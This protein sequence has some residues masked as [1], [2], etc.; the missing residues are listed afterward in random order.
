[1]FAGHLLCAAQEG[2]DGSNHLQGQQLAAIDM[3]ALSQ[4]CNRTDVGQVTLAQNQMDPFSTAVI[5]ATPSG[6]KGMN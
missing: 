3:G 5:E 6:P 4:A 1:M 2:Q